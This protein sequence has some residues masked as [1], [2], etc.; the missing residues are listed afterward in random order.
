M[1]TDF[2]ALLSTPV[3][4]AE[5]PK[6]RPAGQYYGTIAGFKFAESKI[7]KT[8]YVRFTFK[9]V[10]PGA[11][12]AN[13]PALMQRL[14]AAGGTE[15]WAPFKDYYLTEDAKFRLRE[16]IES[17]K[18]PAD[19]RSFAETIPELQNQPVVFDVTEESY[20]GKD[21]DT[22]IRNNVGDVR[23]A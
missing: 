15:K 21:G 17:A 10:Q 8:P 12:I 20:E 23:G 16:L 6:P 4:S 22:G 5:R 11:G 9:G 19:G 2:K 14:E 1:A 3:Q 7:N 18:I 13:D